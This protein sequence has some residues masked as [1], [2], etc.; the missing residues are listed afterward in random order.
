MNKVR[1]GVLSTANFARTRFLPGFMQSEWVDVVAVASRNLEG[2][3]A[4]ATEM[5]IP[6]AY[7]SYEELLAADDIHAIY[8]PLPNHLH[9]DWSIK[10][11][12]AGKHVLCEKPLGLN[13]LDAQRLVDVAAR[14]PKLNAMEAFM[15]RF[16]PQWVTAKAWTD[17]GKIGDLRTIQSFFSYYNVDPT[18]IRN[19]ADIGGGAMLDIGCYCTSLTRFIFDAEPKRVMGIVE[20]DPVTKIDRKCSGIMEFENGTGS[21]TTS[22]QI[23]PYQ[24]VHIVGTTGRIEIEIPFNAPPDVETRMWLETDDGIEETTFPICNQYTLEG[25][26]VSQAILNGDPS[27]TPLSDAIGNMK[28]IDAIFESHEQDGWVEM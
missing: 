16:H 14:Y 27:P 4:F 17:A 7:G 3:Q 1:W 24:R 25:D 6:K 23:S 18:N 22:T 20:R 21:F 8:N 28:V 5:G 9:V 13:A 2:A 15:F 12:E 11:L 19:Q 10:V 26:V